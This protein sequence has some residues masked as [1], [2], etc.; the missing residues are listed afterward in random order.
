MFLNNI[1]KGSTF[2]ALQLALRRFPK[3]SV[4]NSE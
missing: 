3:N 2:Q 1:P 4:A